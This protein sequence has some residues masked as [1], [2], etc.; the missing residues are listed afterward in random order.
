MEQLEFLDHPFFTNVCLFLLLKKEN[1]MR[2]NINF[3][4]LLILK[5][6]EKNA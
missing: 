5:M 6:K 1:K 2:C 4:L 3:W